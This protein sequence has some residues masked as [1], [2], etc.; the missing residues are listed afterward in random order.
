M[1]DGNIE[2]ALNLP[3]VQ[4]DG[5]DTVRARRLDQIRDEL[6]RDWLAPARLAVL[7]R[8]CII[9]NDCRDAVR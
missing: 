2:K 9:R 5:D 1:V 3:R 7:T 6:R 8:V 4:V